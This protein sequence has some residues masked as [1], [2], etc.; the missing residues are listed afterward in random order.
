MLL[1]STPRFVLQ[2]CPVAADDLIN[3]LYLVE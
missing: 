1:V 2:Q 3:N